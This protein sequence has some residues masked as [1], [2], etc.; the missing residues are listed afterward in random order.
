MSYSSPGLLSDESRWLAK[1]ARQQKM[2]IHTA[3][4]GVS[5]SN[6]PNQ[7]DLLSAQTL[8]LAANTYKSI[9][10]SVILGS[11]ALSMD[12]GATSVTY[13][14][15]SNVNMNPVGT[16]DT[17]FVFTVSGTTS[18]GLNRVIIQTISA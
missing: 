10:F 4:G 1:V 13:P 16:L 17:S 6:T 11:V 18:D 2:A 5:S 15:G 7:H 8:T 12:G 9:S 14:V 3:L